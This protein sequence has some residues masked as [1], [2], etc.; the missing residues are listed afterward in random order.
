[1]SQ[2]ERLPNRRPNVTINLTHENAAYAVTVG[3]DPASEQ[4]REIFTHG[5]KVG[6]QLDGLLDD[7]CILLSFMLQHGISASSFAGSM[8]Y[9]RPTNEPSSVIGRLVR[10]LAEHET[11]SFNS[12]VV[13]GA[14]ISLS[15]EA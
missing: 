13:P 12:L 1:M 6:S 15:G 9:S 7:A 11:N 3:F 4:M 5:S 2:R 14:H 10:L 8:G